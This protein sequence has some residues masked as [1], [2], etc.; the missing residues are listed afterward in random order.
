MRGGAFFF[1]RQMALWL[2]GFW[3]FFCYGRGLVC[4]CV[5]SRMCFFL[6]LTH[7]CVGI[8]VFEVCWR[9]EGFGARGWD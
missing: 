3:I 4:V 8:L 2:S 7:Q 6:V 5:R 1:L 9:L